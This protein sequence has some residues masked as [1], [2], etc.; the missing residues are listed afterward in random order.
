MDV[1]D[2][3]ERIVPT[4]DF[5]NHFFSLNIDR[6]WRRRLVKL[7]AVPPNGTVLDICTGTADV[8]VAFARSQPTTRIV[9][10]DFSE[11]MLARGAEKI[12]ASGCADRIKLQVGDAASLEIPDNAF[13]AVCVAFGLRNVENREKGIAEMTRT[14]KP[15]GK[16]LIL[17]FVPP[18]DTVFG[19]MYGWYLRNVMPAIG[20]IISGF[21]PSYTYLH[22]SI[23]EFM[24]PEE[25]IAVMERTGL[26]DCAAE[27]LTG[28][29]AYLF[30]GVKAHK[31]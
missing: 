19:S 13:D 5:L 14:A 1:H 31:F 6:R 11:K 2:M 16:V 4:Y 17:E 3:F 20:G 12:T 7:A 9:G 28:G 30:H 15:G 23:S 29:I 21:R 8:A 18:R 22:S 10:V 27:R 24:Q 25:I 26:I